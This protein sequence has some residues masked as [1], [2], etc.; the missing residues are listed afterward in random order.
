MIHKH[1]KSSRIGNRKINMRL[2]DKK[3]KSVA[4]KYYGAFKVTNWPENLDEY[5][6]EV[7]KK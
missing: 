3:S 7:K 2:K 5:V 1:K 6:M 4:D